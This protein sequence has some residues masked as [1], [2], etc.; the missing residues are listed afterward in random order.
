MPVYIGADQVDD[1]K[2]DVGG[3]DKVYSGSDLIWPP[4]TFPYVFENTNVTDA[5]TPAGATGAWITLGGGGEAGNHGGHED[6]TSSS[7]GASGG[8]GGGGA[9]FFDKTFVYVEDLGA[10]W[11]LILGVRG[12]GGA[13][14]DGTASRFVSG[15]VDITANGG[16]GGVGGTCSVSGLGAE[17]YAPKA[18][19]GANA[20]G[21][22][23]G[24][25]AGGGTGGSASWTGDN[26]PN[27]SSPL[28]AGTATQVSGQ[29]TTPGNGGNGGNAH[30]SGNSRHYASGGGGGGGGSGYGNGSAG[31]AGTQDEGGNG[32][33]GGVAG[34][35]VEWVNTFVAKD[36]SYPL[37]TTAGNWSFTVPSWLRTG[38]KVD[39]ILL[40]GGR[41]GTQGV[42]NSS[43]PGGNA[44][45]FASTTLIVGTHISVG[46]TIGGVIG[47]GGAING[48]NGG[49]TTLTSGGSL[50]AAGA[51]AN[52]GVNGSNGNSPGTYTLN[53]KSY[54][55][56]VGGTGAS[57][58]A[59]TAGT[60]PGAGG[61]GGGSLFF[62]GQNG[63]AGAQGG[64]WIRA[65]QV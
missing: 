23:T 18:Y 39:V 64:V 53:G 57:S 46:Q 28:S 30:G 10:T 44:G 59:G 35:K 43:R 54:T 37:N 33:N 47:A 31:A 58:A 20:R 12:T 11:S 8:T 4:I 65:Y 13:G 61:G 21:N 40:G 17:Y 22:S 48:G 32:G 26:A 55:G 36:K 51:T 15:S 6:S 2:N 63:G 7:G 24:G 42:S 45:A 16:A 41:G 60:A 38:D 50:S 14:M 19:A 52:N 29:T 62:V 3:Y 1:I 34:N 56:G 27:T 9:A 25:G 5:E 49:N